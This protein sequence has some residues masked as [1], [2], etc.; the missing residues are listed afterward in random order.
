MY[1]VQDLDSVT[2]RDR[3]KCRAVELRKVVFQWKVEEPTLHVVDEH[4]KAHVLTLIPAAN[5]WD[6][7]EPQGF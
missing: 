4:C 5:T 6:A 1:F 2:D 3:K 7:L